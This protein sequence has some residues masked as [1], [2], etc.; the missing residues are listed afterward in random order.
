[1][2]APRRRKLRGLTVGAFL[3]SL[4]VF[5]GL[6]AWALLGRA[7]ASG[8]DTS[9]GEGRPAEAPDFNLPLLEQGLL[10]ERLG[11]RLGSAFADRRLRLAEL[12]GTP[13]VIN[14]WASWCDPCRREAPVLEAGWRTW[15]NRGVLFLGVD[16]QDLSGDARAF[17]REFGVDYPTA[18]D[19]D[20]DV[21]R[22]WG[23]VGIP[24]SYFLDRDAKVVGHVIGL[25]TQGSLAAGVRAALSGRPTSV[26]GRAST[27]LRL[28][29]VSP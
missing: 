21:A 6:L 15:R 10:S 7:P 2:D 19:Q 22:R 20:R 25:V 16:V 24:E 9:L 8:I 3:A 28:K 4:L 13:V 5:V 29:R 14:F 27:G 11:N 18:R 17:L 1:M 12:R 26:R 23:A